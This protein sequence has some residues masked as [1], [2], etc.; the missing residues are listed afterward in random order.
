MAAATTSVATF[1]RNVV[2]GHVAVVKV[3]VTATATVYATAS[4]GLPFDLTQ[5]LQ[6]AAP[7]SLDNLNPADIVDIYPTG[8]ST[9]GFLACGL[10]IG[11]PTYTNKALASQQNTG[12]K[13]LATCPATVR[14]FGT[15]SANHA[16]LG[17]I[18]DGAVTDTISFHL[19]VAIGGENV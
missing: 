16:A 5:I 4:G 13:V 17:E 9:G 10:T 15:G 1:G 7:P 11:T 3:T 8:L 18:A 12:G 19:V 6:Q 14:L 2:L